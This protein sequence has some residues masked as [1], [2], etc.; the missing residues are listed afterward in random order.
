MIVEN[1]QRGY[2]DEYE[3][4]GFWIEALIPRTIKR[5]SFEAYSNY[6]ESLLQALIDRAP[7]LSHL[8]FASEIRSSRFYEE[9]VSPSAM[10]NVRFLQYS[11]SIMDP[12]LLQWFAE[13]PQLVTLELT[14]DQEDSEE[15]NVPEIEYQPEAFQALTTLKVFTCDHGEVAEQWN[16][17]KQIW[18]TPLVKRLTCVEVKLSE[19]I[20][21]G[22]EEADQGIRSAGALS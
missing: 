8:E 2:R 14:L 3:D 1:N 20:S 5:I 21:P 13:M 19:P 6:N 7:E 17:L 22:L 15:P 18:R 9:I 10:R 11:G 12:D 4:Y 16:L